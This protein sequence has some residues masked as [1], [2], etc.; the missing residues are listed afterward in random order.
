MCK[1]IFTVKKYQIISYSL[2]MLAQFRDSFYDP[3]KQMD[4]VEDFF[5]I[6]FKTYISE[7]IVQIVI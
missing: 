6:H 2:T 7:Y 4:L 1:Q 5:I 3:L